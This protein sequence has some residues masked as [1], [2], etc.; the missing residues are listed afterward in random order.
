MGAYKKEEPFEPP[1]F[2]AFIYGDWWPIPVTYWQMIV[3]PYYFRALP[4]KISSD[5]NLDPSW[6]RRKE[7]KF[8]NVNG[9]KKML[10]ITEIEP[11]QD[12]RWFAVLEEIT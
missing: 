6:W 4:I 3:K 8:I 5:H 1:L 7:V 12:N 10:R 11:L 9:D 2:F